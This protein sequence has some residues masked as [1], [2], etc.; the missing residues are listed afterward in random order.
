MIHLAWGG[1]YRHSMV[2]I[3]FYELY[4]SPPESKKK[5]KLFVSDTTELLV[6]LLLT[7]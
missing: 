6:L 5:K 1:G 3:G 7:S 4:L 2:S